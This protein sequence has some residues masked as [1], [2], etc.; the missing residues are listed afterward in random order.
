MCPN[1][2]NI[3]FQIQNAEQSLTAWTNKPELIYGTAFIGLSPGH[4][5]DQDCNVLQDYP[6]MG[7]KVLNIYAVHPFTKENIPIIVC[8]TEENVN[9]ED[10]EAFLGIPE[11]NLEHKE[12][13]DKANILY[14]PQALDDS[15]NNPNFQNSNQAMEKLRSLKIGGYWTSAKLRDWLISR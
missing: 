1:G 11:A 9:S 8:G 12:I 10:P 7:F 2:T 4:F 3:E 14:R 13:A 6:K 15:G 5:L